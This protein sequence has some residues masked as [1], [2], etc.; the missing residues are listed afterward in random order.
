VRY[1]QRHRCRLRTVMLNPRFDIAC[2]TGLPTPIGRRI[3]RL[4]RRAVRAPN[5]SAS[6]SVAFA[7]RSN[8]TISS[9]KTIL[10]R[11]T[12]FGNIISNYLK[13]VFDLRPNRSHAPQPFCNII[14]S[15]G[16]ACPMELRLCSVLFHSIGSGPYQTI[17][18]LK[19]VT[20]IWYTHVVRAG[21]LYLLE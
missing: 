15:S 17:V 9:W 11:D 5:R 8:E 18:I 14:T 16:M 10:K 7:A 3:D 21:P 19:W 12:P 13:S 2:N 20:F 4:R 1:A 6:A